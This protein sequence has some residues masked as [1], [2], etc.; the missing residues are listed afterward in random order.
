M[1]LRV[2]PRSETPYNAIALLHPL[3][4]AQIT[5]SCCAKRAHV[6]AQ[7]TGSCCATTCSCISTRPRTS[8][9]S[10]TNRLVSCCSRSATCARAMIGAPPRRYGRTR[11]RGETAAVDH[12]EVTGSC[13]GA[14]SSKG[15]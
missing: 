15:G 11:G 6:F 10:G 8:L 1:E 3:P 14:W 7:I 12:K 4:T 2:G 5:G 13:G 9:R